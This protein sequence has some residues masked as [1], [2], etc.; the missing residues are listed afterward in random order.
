MSFHSSVR[1]LLRLE[2][3]THRQPDKRKG[4]LSTIDFGSLGITRLDQV[5]ELSYE[6]D[7]RPQRRIEAKARD[8]ARHIA[9]SGKA[10]TQTH[11]LPLVE[12]ISESLAS[13]SRLTAIS[14]TADD[15]E[16]LIES[17]A[18]LAVM[19][20]TQ[21]AVAAIAGHLSG[22][23]VEDVREYVRSLKGQIAGAIP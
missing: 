8:W 10:V 4:F 15:A 1:S 14:G 13:I 16:L 17:E 18:L 23:T 19:E 2:L 3:I 12:G 11:L 20:S 21:R 6:L 7:G 5:L 9:N 22:G